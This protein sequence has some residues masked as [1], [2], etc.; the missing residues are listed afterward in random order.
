MRVLMQIRR[1]AFDKFG[2]DTRQMLKYKE[3]LSGLGVD[4]SISRELRP[5]LAEVDIV[6]LF[7]LDRPLET[8]V[9][10]RNAQ[11]RGRPACIGGLGGTDPAKGVR[12]RDS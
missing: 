10:L 2:G 11:S 9:Q 12:G 8:Y 4:V 7:N 1:D 5:R 3:H 6:H